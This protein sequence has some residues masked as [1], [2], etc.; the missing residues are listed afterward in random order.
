MGEEKKAK[1]ES[2]AEAR[3]EP[4]K[5]QTQPPAPVK[6]GLIMPIS[7]M[8]DYSE[9]HWAEVRQIVTDAIREIRD[10]KFE[11]AMVSDGGPVE[12]IQNR[13][14]Q[15]VAECPIVVC[16]VSGRNGNVMFELGIAVGLRQGDSDH[17]GRFQ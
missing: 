13:I 5:E 4:A 14:V 2:E 10:P 8:G 11:V 16:D 12:V 15:N 7:A 17:H 3:A 6:C 1:R 9:Q